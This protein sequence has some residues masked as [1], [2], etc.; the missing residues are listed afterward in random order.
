MMIATV[1]LGVAYGLIQRWLASGRVN[2][3]A[4]AVLA[5]L[6]VYGLVVLFGYIGVLTTAIT[7][8]RSRGPSALPVAEVRSEG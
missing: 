2:D 7:A 6:A 8:M 5:M 3:S 1:I 4:I